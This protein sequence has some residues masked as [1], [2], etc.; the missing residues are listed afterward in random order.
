MIFWLFFWF[1]SKFDPRNLFFLAQTCV[2]YIGGNFW[3]GKITSL[4][5]FCK[6]IVKKVHL[7]LYSEIQGRK[8]FFQNLTP[9]TLFFRSE[10]VPIATAGKFRWE[11][12]LRTKFSRYLPCDSRRI[13]R[14]A[15]CRLMSMKMWKIDFFQSL[16]SKY[17]P[18]QVL[19]NEKVIRIDI[20]FKNYKLRK[21]QNFSLFLT[22]SNRKWGVWSK[23]INFFEKFH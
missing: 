12:T 20:R 5:N 7:R 9:K 15:P 14:L 2:H 10:N 17:R 18:N 11:K 8:F 23:K 19:F 16:M 3:W 22:I 1:F 21:I 13:C 4:Q 6:K